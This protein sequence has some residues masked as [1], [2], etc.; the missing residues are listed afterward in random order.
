MCVRVKILMVHFV[1]KTV[2]QFAYAVH[3]SAFGRQVLGIREAAMCVRVR[4]STVH[5]A[6][7]AR[8]TTR[9]ACNNAARM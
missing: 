4:I 1:L 6:L 7:I 8:E 2:V 5:R 3:C 9:S